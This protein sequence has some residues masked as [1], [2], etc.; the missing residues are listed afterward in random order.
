MNKL[1]STLLVATSLVVAPLATGCDD[2]VREDSTYRQSDDGTVT[3]TH[4]EVKTNDDGDV[5]KTQEKSVE[6]P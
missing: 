5:T 1:L 2:T 3:K 6:R 4:E